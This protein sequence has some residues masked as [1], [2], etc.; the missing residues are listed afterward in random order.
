MKYLGL[1]EIRKKY[2]DFFEARAHRVLPSFSLV[3]QNDKSL[4]LIGAGMAPMKKYF[5]GEAVPP[6]KRVSTCQKCIRTGDIENVGK[7][8]RH[9]TFF[10]MLGNFSFGDYFKKEAIAW[11]WEFL[12]E[13]LEIAEEDLWVTVYLDDD[14]AH[15]IWHHDI[16]VAEERIV[17]LGK[18]DN[19][20]ELAVGPSGP[21]SEI[22]VDRGM[23]YSNGDPNE[24]PG[25]EG[26]RF[27]EVWNLVFTQFDK[28]EEGN[29]H[30][31]DHPNID[32]G[33]GL[34]R[35]ATVLQKTNNIFEI[36]AIQEILKSITQRAGYEYGSDEKKDTSVR[37][38]TDHI[39]AMTFM[40]S[41]GIVPTNEGRGYVL[42]RLIRRAARHGKMLGIEGAFL[43]DLSS[44]VINSWNVR[45]TELDTK[46]E[47]IRNVLQREEERFHKTLEGGLLRLEEKMEELRAQKLQVLP[48]ADAF[49][50]YDTFGF[51]LDLTR[52]ILEDEGFSVD[53]EGFEAHM[54]EQRERARS[55]RDDSD[56]IGWASQG[57]GSLLDELPPSTFHGYDTLKEDVELTHLLVEGEAV[58]EATEGAAVTVILE[59]TPFYGEGGGQVGDTGEVR[60][61]NF[62]VDITD[63]KKNKFGLIYGLGKVTSG[64]AAPGA[65]TAEVEGA[66]RE[67]IRRNHSVTHLLHRALKDQLGE[68][69]QQAGS[70]VGPDVMRFDITHYEAI[71]PEDLA[72]VEEEVNR[73]IYHSLPVRAEEMSLEEAKSAGA[74]GLFED[75]Y[76]D[77]VR[78]ISMGDYSKELCGGTHVDNT[79]QIGMMKILSEGGIAAGTRRLEVRTGL[80]VY[81][82]L[83]DLEEEQ[84]EAKELLKATNVSLVEKVQ[85]H[86]ER[87]KEVEREL[88]QAKAKLAQLE[89]GELGDQVQEICGINYLTA[90][91]SGMDVDALR[92]MAENLREEHRAVVV[93]ATVNG[94]KIQLVA[95]SPKEAITSGVK[96][97]ALIR[98]VA[99]AA[100]GGGGG[101]DDMAT[102]GAKDPSRLDEALQG[103]AGYIEKMVSKA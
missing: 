58:S 3:P 17:R 59:P 57:G 33:M 76:G 69:V 93:L 25:D 48:G 67:R 89:A 61:E 100:G 64:V 81:E 72:Q 13:E 35:M 84:G 9:A 16:G 78:V 12:T 68:H 49:T 103:V 62:T 80:G 52:E 8:D 11:A 2:L 94:E 102:A 79:A 99:K 82:Y 10:E 51:P 14:E 86:L 19:F 71:S 65:V 53:L 54:K 45:Y 5:T 101:K 66:R 85:S 40:I 56:N 97:G 50:L 1:H 22:Y 20:W 34:E 37:V 42:R 44:Q 90:K 47:M 6:A 30:P 26:D 73:Q 46:A 96:A 27:I 28:D 21:C 95:A 70:Y 91:V 55:A 38:I 87:Q 31:L 92:S 36:D 98:E 18:E 77:H 75:K 41:D 43:Y 15:D 88:E 63:T 32:T 23:A 60:G 4:L 29:Y 74:V 83:R 7:T 39:R 24:K